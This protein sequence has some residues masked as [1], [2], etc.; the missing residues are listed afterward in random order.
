VGELEGQLLAISS[1]PLAK[2]TLTSWHFRGSSS[3]MNLLFLGNRFLWL[4][5][6]GMRD[7]GLEL[8]AKS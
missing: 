3:L 4:Q 8:K 6:L 2:T 7:F 1:W 5:R